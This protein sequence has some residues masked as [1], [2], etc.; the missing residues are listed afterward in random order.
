MLGKSLD[1][2]T[3]QK[4]LIHATAYNTVA[5]IIKKNMC[6]LFFLVGNCIGEF[7]TFLC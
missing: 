7:S 4:G 1:V 3:K 6:I 5:Y 2:Y